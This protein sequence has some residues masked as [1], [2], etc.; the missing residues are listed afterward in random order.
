[1]ES[2]R[3]HLR[4][5]APDDLDTLFALWNDPDM[6]RYLWGNR[7]LSREEVAEIITRSEQLYRDQG[8]GLWKVCDRASGA[9]VGCGGYWY[10]DDESE[11]RILFG[12]APQHWGMGLATELAECL[13]AYGFSTLNLDRIIG[14]T[15]ATN[16]S[17]QRVMEKAGMRFMER[18]R[19]NGRDIMYYLIEQGR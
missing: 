14:A 8:A 5:I 3:L 12:L 1:M 4:P 9:I 13:I 18:D 2:Q 11:L 10:F 6:C 15:E 19:G 7:E 16:V 17:S